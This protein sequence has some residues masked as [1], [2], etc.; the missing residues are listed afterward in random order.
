[1]PIISA[2]NSRVRKTT[3]KYGIEIPTSVEYAK[4]IDRR[5]KNRAWQDA[6]N[7]EMKNASVAFNILES[8]EHVPPGYTKSSSHFVFDIR[9]NFQCKARWV[10]SRMA[11]K[12]LTQR[13]P[14]MLVL[15]LEK[16]SAFC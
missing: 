16:A 9:I 4:E 12:R 7:L 10:K 14:T 1:M 5:N 3:H 15:C 13:S 2:V 6:I 11:A 8:G